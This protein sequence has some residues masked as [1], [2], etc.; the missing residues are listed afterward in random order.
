M[1]NW[2]EVGEVVQPAPKK[3]PSPKEQTELA[4]AREAARQAQEAARLAGRFEELNGKTGTGWG[5]AIPL[6][7]EAIG[8]FNPN[9]A[10]MQSITNRLAPTLRAAGSGAMSDK[11][12]ALFRR[13]VPNPDFPGPTNS[14]ISKRI[15]EDAQRRVQYAAFLD[16][17][18]AKNGTLIGAEAAWNARQSAPKA[19]PT[20]AARPPAAQPVRRPVTAGN[21]WKIV[22]E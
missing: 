12:V 15:R 19:R 3:G 22:Q 1:Q 6:V 7:S 20:V 17:W 4:N 5:M 8:A 11:D 14:A 18:V 10:E 13:S 9:V 2:W 16:D 21:G